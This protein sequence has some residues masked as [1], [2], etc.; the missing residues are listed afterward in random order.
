MCVSSVAGSSVAYIQDIA[1]SVSLACTVL[2]T[3]IR[4]FAT[5]SEQLTPV[6]TFTFLNEFFGKMA[7]IIRRNEGVID[8]FIGDSIMALF[9]RSPE[10]AI[11]AAIA[12]VSELQDFNEICKERYG[13]EKIN[14]GVGIHTGNLM[15]GTIGEQGRMDVTV[16]SDAVNI[17]SRIENLTKAFGASILNSLI[18]Y[19]YMITLQYILVSDS[20]LID[21]AKF[22]HRFLGTVQVKGKRKP[23]LLY[24]IL[25]GLPEVVTHAKINST[26]DLK[27]ALLLY[28]SK[29]FFEAKE[30][31]DSLIQTN[32]KDKVL[33]PK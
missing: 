31:F 1:D 2:F 14:I 8:K 25:Q 27:K 22:E 9:P 7:P 19:S 4:S 28:E 24:E 33:Y 23:I 21:P 20:S 30:V 5:L 6:E 29:N 18:R 11:N 13:F 10:D 3:D 12:M 15:L 17:A 26:P 16:I 32:P